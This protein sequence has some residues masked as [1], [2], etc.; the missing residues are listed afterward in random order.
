[1]AAEERDVG[2]CWGA[3]DG[4]QSSSIRGKKGPR[5]PGHRARPREGAAGRN[6]QNPGKCSELESPGSSGE[7]ETTAQSFI[8]P[9]P[10]PHFLL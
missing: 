4:T 6:T 3:H 8:A 5:D 10:Q 7:P 9:K 2:Q 1:M